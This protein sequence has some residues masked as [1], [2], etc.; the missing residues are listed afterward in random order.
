MAKF[1]EV[2][3]DV[4]EDSMCGSESMIPTRV[5]RLFWKW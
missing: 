2:T 5:F 3:I 1:I 4:S